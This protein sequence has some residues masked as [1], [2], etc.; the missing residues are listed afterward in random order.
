MLFNSVIGQEGIRDQLINSA[1]ENRVS[2][3]LLFHGPPGSGKFPLAMAFAQYLNCS[4]PGPDDSCGVCPSCK[5]A[6]KYIHPDIHFVFPVV[7]G[8]KELAE[9]ISDN[10]IAQWREYLEAFPYPGLQS[11]LR[12]IKVENKQAKIFK[13]EAESI[14]HK[15]HL[16]AYESD[17]KIVLIWL[18]E[19]MNGAAA[20]KLLKIIEEPPEKTIFIMIAQST[21]EIL[22]TILSRTQL[23]R[24]NKLPDEVLAA[25]LRQ[26][27]H[28]NDQII[29]G[30]T[31][32]ADGDYLAALN[33]IE[34]DEQN[35]I[36]YEHFVGWMRLTYSYNI[37]ELL[38]LLPVIAEMG[39]E[40]QK[41]FFVFCLR[42]IRENFH[43][44]MDVKEIIRMSPE[45]KHFSERFHKYIHPGNIEDLQSLF[46]EAIS[47]ISMNANPRILFL[48][49]STRIYHL[50]RKTSVQ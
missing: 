41:D 38:E 6:E 12:F 28:N 46:S 11:W 43:T 49:M 48:D 25:Y 16:K 30:V 29:N 40:K 15:L 32:L 34:S 8:P 18:P 27:F 14:L 19:K 23:V 31:R 2:H 20:N 4:N 21:E 24:V 35:R 26:K 37:P 3:A 1:R 47:Q 45:E 33:L 44:N 39:R 42:M 22:P 9:P 5:K 50:L 17:L 7:T 10:Y 13:K 36:Y